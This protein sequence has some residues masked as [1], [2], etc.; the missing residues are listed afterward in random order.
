MT[1]EACAIPVN[2]VESIDK[3][4]VGA[5]FTIENMKREDGKITLVIR[6]LAAETFQAYTNGVFL[7]SLPPQISVYL[8][9][10]GGSMIDQEKTEELV[11]DISDT[12][13]KQ[14]NVRIIGIFSPKPE[15]MG[16]V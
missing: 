4:P 10:S 6:G 5:Q 1:I 14:S 11:I 12:L 3:V 9:S 7:K 2:R 15:I 13:F 8:S 16:Y